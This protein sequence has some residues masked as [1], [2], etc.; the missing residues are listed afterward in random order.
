MGEIFKYISEEIK[1]IADLVKTRKVKVLS[2]KKIQ[3]KA[4]YFK[5]LKPKGFTLEIA[6]SDYWRLNV[7][8]TIKAFITNPHLSFRITDAYVSNVGSVATPNRNIHGVKIHIYSFQQKRISNTQKHFYRTVIPLKKAFDFYNIIKDETYTHDG[9]IY[10]RYT[11]GLINIEFD[12]KQFHL[13]TVKFD[14]TKYLV[15]DCLDKIA[16]DEFSELSWSIMVATGYLSG[17]LVQD[18]EYTFCYNNKQL[19]GFSNYLYSQSRDSI[20]SFYTPINT[21]PYS[22]IKDNRKIAKKYYDKIAEINMLQFS[23]LCQL[24]HKEAELKAIVL[25][26]TESVNRS[27]LLM[28]AGLSIALEGLC[29]YFA[30]KHFNKIKPI[31][32]KNLAKKFKSELMAVL[33]K[34]KL[35][36][37][38]TGADIIDNKINNINSPTNREKLKTPFTIL[39]IPLTAIDKEILEYRNDF[40]HGNINLKPQKGKK[41]YSMDAFE[42]SLRLLTLLNMA[43][44]KM[45]GYKGYIINHVK[46][47]EE[48]LK[49]II[50]EEY[51]REI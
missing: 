7:G 15:I 37:D 4:G 12:S 33:Q 51:Y 47:Q 28:P 44:M 2:G 21:N 50:Q 6:S 49:K 18:E 10:T 9:N 41:T 23:N 30:S 5:K 26:I 36:R 20:K 27:L 16:L 14:K 46:T 8:K 39:K 1:F 19:K 24:I 13:F 3:N 25:L 34:Y 31:K 35:E 11:R 17:H 43:V 48:G 45:I 38:F 22:W 29:G 40:L 42:I 32:D